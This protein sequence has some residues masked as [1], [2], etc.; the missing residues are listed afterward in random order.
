[1]KKKRKKEK[2][3]EPMKLERKMTWEIIKL[4]NGSYQWILKGRV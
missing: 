4:P 1:M 3:V 2:A